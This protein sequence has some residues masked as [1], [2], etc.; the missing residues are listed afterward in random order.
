MRAVSP[1]GE[2]T[3]CQSIGMIGVGKGKADFRHQNRIVQ[4]CLERIGEDHPKDEI[5]LRD[6][7]PREGS[8][9]V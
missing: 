9:E 1:E 6:F 4:G 2:E 7:G 3:R 8:K 5:M